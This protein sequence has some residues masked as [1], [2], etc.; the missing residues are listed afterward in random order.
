MT[1]VFI[2]FRQGKIVPRSSNKSYHTEHVAFVL[3]LFLHK[4]FLLT[5]KNNLEK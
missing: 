5:S 1:S 4:A 3:K 2:I